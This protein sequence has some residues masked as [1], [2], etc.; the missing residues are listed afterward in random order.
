MSYFSINFIFINHTPNE[1]TLKSNQI[2]TPSA[3]QKKLNN[4]RR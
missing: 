1:K 4:V 2:F 3:E